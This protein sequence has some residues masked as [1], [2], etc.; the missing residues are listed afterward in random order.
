MVTVAVTVAVRSGASVSLSTA[1]TSAVSVPVVASAG[2]TTP[3]AAPEPTVKAPATADTVS[4][5]AA[6]EACESRAVTVASPPFSTTD[7]GDSAIVTV[8]APS[9]SVVVTE[10]STSA[11]VL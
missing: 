4:V 8:G 3:P 9:S 1:V 6:P 10:T 11:T 5:V 2:I 7:A